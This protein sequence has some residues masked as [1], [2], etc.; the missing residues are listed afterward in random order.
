ME[1]L[2]EAL[3]KD[4]DGVVMSSELPPR[5]DQPDRGPYGYENIPLV[6]NPIP[7]RQKCF[8]L[9]GE[10]LEAHKKVTQG[11]ADN[12]FIERHPKGSNMD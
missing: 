7:Q 10:R 5:K 11:W 8:K 6:A 12:W 1:G 3:Q 9:Q 2:R 4:Y